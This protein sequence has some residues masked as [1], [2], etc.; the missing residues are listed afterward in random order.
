VIRDRLREAGLPV[1][2]VFT[3]FELQTL[4]A[5]VQIDSAKLRSMKTNPK[6]LCQS[7]GDTIFADR[8]GMFEHHI[9]VVS[10]DIDVYNFQDVMWAYATRCRPGVD[11]FCF[12]NTLGFPLVPYQWQGEGPPD[13]A[14]KIVSN[15]MLPVEYTDGPNWEVGDFENGFPEKIKQRVLRDWSK[16]GF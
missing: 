8:S 15:C 11:D 3:P 5:V 1:K 6:A 14:T 10:D 9:L 4:W 7:I 13:V 16:L 12:H 2:E